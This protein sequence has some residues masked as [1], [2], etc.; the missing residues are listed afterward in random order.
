MNPEQEYTYED[1]QSKFNIVYL[2]NTEYDPDLDVIL[3]GNELTSEQIY[4]DSKQV[5]DEN[6][7]FAS[8]YLTGGPYKSDHMKKMVIK[9]S[10]KETGFGIF[11]K[12]DLV[13]DTILGS[14]TGKVN[15]GFGNADYVWAIPT[16]LIPVDPSQGK[17]IELG[18]DSSQA[19][20]YLR[21]I[22]HHDTG[23]NCKA[24]LVPFDNRWY[25]LYVTIRDIQKGE[26]LLTNYGTKYF[27]TR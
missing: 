20:N 3:D 4:I 13:K 25:I 21:F 23:F 12:Q 27:E 11:A 5:Y 2:E 14:Y 1:F 16:K 24:I 7:K 10:S 22:N 17:E 18:I 15:F 9:W 26:E 19:G 6:T 8:D